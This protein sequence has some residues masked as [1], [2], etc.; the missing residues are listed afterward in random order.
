ML[1]NYFKAAAKVNLTPSLARLNLTQVTTGSETAPFQSLRQL[2][3]RRV[4]LICAGL[5]VLSQ[6]L[7]LINIQF[8]RGHNFDEFHY[9][10]SAKQF[11]E[12]RENQNWEHPPL[13]KL[14]MAA[15]IGLWGDIPIGWRYMS[16]VFGTFT[17]IGM[18]VWALVLFGSEMTALWV[19]LLTLFNGLLYVQSRIGMLDTFMFGFIVWALAAF[20]AAWRPNQHVRQTRRLIAVTGIFLGLGT[21]CKWF[22]VIPWVTC[23]AL[24]CVV[25]LL[26][27]WQT[28]FG[29]QDGADDWYH[30]QL[31]RHVRLVDWVWGLGFVPLVTY[32]ATFIPYFIIQRPPVGFMDL[33]LMQ[34]K[35]YEGQLRVLGQHP[36]MSQWPDWPLLT[37]PIWYAFDKEGSNS[38]W[39][40]GVVLLGNPLIMWGGLMALFVCL[41]NW[42]RRRQRDA[43]L[44]L[45]F[46]A[47]FFGSWVLIPR[48]IAFYYYYYPAGMVLSLA[49][50]Y[51]FHHATQAGGALARAEWAR[52]LFLS[53]C[54]GLFIYFFP[55]LAALRIPA[56]SFVKWMWL[57]T[58][59]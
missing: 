43:F 15:G 59:I 45:V 26:Q 32:F 3:T 11:L 5:F 21:G 29:A 40:R 18:Y 23:I 44:I 10:P 54:L 56:G 16:T 48:K 34:K 14:I 52:W 36:Y 13:G 22:T 38:E 46:Y 55:I 49:L 39:V 37:R 27:Y 4:L 1:R 24:V 31:W 50:G 7:F 25:K 35:M 58:W 2:F 6:L 19:A 53:C 57:R 17:L 8:P 42:V 41:W 9:V 33:F 12:M 30:P 20:T 51:V 28:R 47:A